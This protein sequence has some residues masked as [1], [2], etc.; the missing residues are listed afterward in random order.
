M[1]APSLALCLVSPKRDVGQ[2][3]IDLRKN[4]LVVLDLAITPTSVHAIKIPFTSSVQSHVQLPPSVLTLN[5]L[6]RSDA[7]TEGICKDCEGMAERLGREPSALDFHSDSDIIPVSQGFTRI[8]FTI[9]CPWFHLSPYIN[10]EP[11]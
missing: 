6:W 10:E 2:S 9:T 5:A 1:D 8:A 3:L 4:N 11:M 7:P